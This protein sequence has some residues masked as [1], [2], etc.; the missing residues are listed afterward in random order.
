RFLAASW[1]AY[2]W[3]SASV[4]SAANISV[5]EGCSSTALARPPIT[6][7]KRTLAS[8]TSRT[9]ALPPRLEICKDLVFRKTPFAQLPPHLVAEHREDLALQL[10]RHCALRPWEENARQT[11]SPG[12]QDWIFRPKQTGRVVAKLAYAAD[13]HVVT[14][15][16]IIARLMIQPAPPLFKDK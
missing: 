13:L 11:S 5:M 16:A 15:V 14:P 12:Y 6:A 4:A 10:D 3:T 8:A 2:S 9:P 7:D 1:A